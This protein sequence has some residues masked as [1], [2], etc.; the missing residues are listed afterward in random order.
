[1][2]EWHGEEFLVPVGSATTGFPTPPR[3][4]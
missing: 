3:W 2:D 1:L 4:K